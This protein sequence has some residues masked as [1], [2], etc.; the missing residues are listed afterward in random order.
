MH[1]RLV[2]CSGCS[3]KPVPL[4]LLLYFLGIASPLKAPGTFD[5]RLSWVQALQEAIEA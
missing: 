2:L 1:E 4:H 5:V 3:A